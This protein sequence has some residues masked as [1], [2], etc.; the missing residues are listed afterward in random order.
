MRLLPEPGD[1]PMHAGRH[2]IT[3]MKKKRHTAY[4]LLE[5]C[6]VTCTP[7]VADTCLVLF[8][9]LELATRLEYKAVLI[10]A[11]RFKYFKRVLN[12]IN[13]F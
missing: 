10:F 12:I 7:T 5:V 2:S 3:E 6:T 4:G 11:R 13:V 8:F 1:I 9:F